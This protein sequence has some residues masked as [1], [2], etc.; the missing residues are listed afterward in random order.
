MPETLIKEITNTKQNENLRYIDD[1]EIQSLK[2]LLQKNLIENQDTKE[3][4]V[5]ETKNA[6]K[7][8]IGPLSA[9]IKN[10]VNNSNRIDSILKQE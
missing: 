7:K 4:L 6:I 5:K 2:E 1:K 10:F 3:K 8:H 9:G